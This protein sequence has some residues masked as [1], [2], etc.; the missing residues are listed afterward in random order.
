MRFTLSPETV[1]AVQ[2]VLNF[3]GEGLES[4]LIYPMDIAIYN[5]G[6]DTK[7][8]INEGYYM[9]L[10]IPVP[11]EF[12]PYADHISVVHVSDLGQL[13]ILPAIHV[14]VGGVECMQ[15]TANS[16]SPYAFVVYLPE[17]GE[18]TSAGTPVSAQGTAQT[19]GTAAIAAFRNT[20]LPELYRRRA[21]NKVYRIIGR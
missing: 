11:D 17:I 18:D 2:G 1:T 14:N 16:F 5:A 9:T 6:T 4:F 12:I 13:E 3:Y 15:F 10:T 20:Y 7:A 21:R 8:T 19:G